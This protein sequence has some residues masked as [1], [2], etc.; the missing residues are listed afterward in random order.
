MRR[1]VSRREA[2]FLLY[3]GAEQGLVFQLQYSVIPGQAL[4]DRVTIDYS[5][6]HEFLVHQLIREA[7]K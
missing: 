7:N 6:R 2:C 3:N 1:T 5:P 4:P